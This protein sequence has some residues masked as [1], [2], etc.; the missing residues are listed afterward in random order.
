MGKVLN[1]S[2]ALTSGF[3]S[4]LVNLDV[5]LILNYLKSQLMKLRVLPLISAPQPQGNGVIVITLNL[6]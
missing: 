2:T 1:L 6:T 5:V 4:T 3:I